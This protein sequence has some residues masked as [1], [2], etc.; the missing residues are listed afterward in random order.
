MSLFAIDKKEVANDVKIGYNANKK[1]R[2]GIW[3]KNNFAGSV[4]IWLV[5]R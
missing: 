1:H 2:E 5:I 3:K 4:F